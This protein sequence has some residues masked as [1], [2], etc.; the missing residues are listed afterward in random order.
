MINQEKLQ[1]I[2]L[3]Y[4]QDQA[5]R[6]LLEE[7]LPATQVEISRSVTIPFRGDSITAVLVDG[8]YLVPVK[9][10]AERMGLDWSSQLQ[11][12]KRDKVLSTWMVVTTIQMPGDDQH[13]EHNCLP[14]RLIPGW[15]FTIDDSRVRPEIQDA[16]IAYKEEMY[17][18]M[19]N[20]LVEGVALNPRTLKTS[21]RHLQSGVGTPEFGSLMLN[22]VAFSVICEASEYL[23][24]DDKIQFLYDTTNILRS[25]Y[26]SHAGGVDEASTDQKLWLIDRVLRTGYRLDTIRIHALCRVTEQKAS[27]LMLQLRRANETVHSLKMEGSNRRMFAIG[28]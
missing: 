7:R 3:Q 6:D 13:R 12:I 15:L 20:Y 24:D 8:E 27:S 26:P 1:Q 10:I 9:P 22:K 18:V 25:I 14:P 4:G 19:H 23:H 5:M 11:R 21:P 28:R 17:E 2:K 16:L